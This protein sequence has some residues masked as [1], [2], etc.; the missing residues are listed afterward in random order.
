MGLAVHV[1]R[2]KR[3]CRSQEEINLNAAILGEVPTIDNDD[4]G[5]N[6]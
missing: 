4:D 6:Q 5:L 1:G 3:F 2:P